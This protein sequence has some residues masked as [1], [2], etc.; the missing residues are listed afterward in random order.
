[1]AQAVNPQRARAQSLTPEVGTTEHA[2][3]VLVLLEVGG[4]VL[5]RRYFK[6][7]HGG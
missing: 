1:M 3:F 5:L 6:A 4:L 2:L 7:A